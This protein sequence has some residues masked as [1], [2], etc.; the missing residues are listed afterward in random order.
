MPTVATDPVPS[1][2]GLSSPATRAFAVTPSD[3]DELVSIVRGLWVGTLGNITGRL[4]GDSADVV[5]AG[6]PAG[7]FLPF[8]F[9]VI[10]STGTTAGS[11]VGLY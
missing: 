6:I 1:S 3:S 9:R 8:R 4:A 5:I 11:L 2:Y 7:T 10:R